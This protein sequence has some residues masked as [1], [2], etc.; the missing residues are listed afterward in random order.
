M[1]VKK[2]I[3]LAFA[4]AAMSSPMLAAELKVEPG[5]DL[6]AENCAQCHGKD[7]RGDGDAVE[8]RNVDIPDLRTLT[9]RNGGSFPLRDVV[10]KID[11]RAE[12]ETHGERF[13]PAWGEAF[14]FD[15]ERGSALAHARILNLVLYLE[16]LQ[17]D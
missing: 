3:P 2:L 10:R 9:K 15:E 5:A 7:G 11:G 6:F 13:M 17:E 1:T 16:G 14:S 8:F 4:I 12:L